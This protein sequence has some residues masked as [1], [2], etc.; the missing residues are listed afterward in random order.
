[1]NGKNDSKLTYKK[2]QKRESGIE[3]IRKVTIRLENRT[4]PSIVFTSQ[5][6]IKHW[7]FWYIIL[8]VIMKFYRH[9]L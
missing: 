2:E 1:M 3:R 7:G 9:G 6:F 4:D 5:I 8:M